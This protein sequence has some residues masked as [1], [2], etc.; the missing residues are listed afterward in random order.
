MANPPLPD[1][2]SSSLSR[3][4]RRPFDSTKGRSSILAGAGSGKTRTLVH[5]LAQDLR[6]GTPAS[7]IVAFTFTE[8]AAEELLAR[9]HAMR[10]QYMPSV[11]LSGIFIGTIHAWCLQHLLSQPAFFNITPVDELHLDA[12]AGRLYSFLKLEDVYKKPFPKGIR[13]FLADLDIFY[14]EHL[15]LDD[16]PEHIAPPIT[17]FLT[18]LSQNRLL[19]FGGMIRSAVEHLEATGSLSDLHCLYVDEYQ[20]V[21]PAQTALLQAMLPPNGKLCVVGD[22]LQSIYN[23][24]GSDV[25]RILEFRH[26]FA[27][28]EVFRLSTNY[29]SRPEILEFANTVADDIVMRDREKVMRTGRERSARKVIHWVSTEDESHQA[30]TIARIV[31]QFHDAGVPYSKIAILMRSVATAGQP[32]YEALTSVEV[33]V[34]CPILGRSAAFIDDFLLPVFRWLRTDQT[35]PRSRKEEQQQEGFARSVW[36]SVSPWLPNPGAEYE[37]WSALNRWHDLLRT[38]SSRSFNIRQCLYEFLDQCGVRIGPDDTE[39]MMGVGLCSQIIR[40]V[41]E[42]HRRR[43]RNHKRRSAVGVLSE[44]YYAVVRNHTRFGESLPLRQ[45]AEEVLLTTV[46]QAK[47]LEWPIVCLP[48]LDSRRFPLPV[49][50]INSEYPAELTE[51]YGTRIDDE[52]RLFYVAVTRAKERL[53]LL[54]TAGGGASRRSVFLEDVKRR[55]VLPDEGLV[56][57]TNGAWSV[58]Q[59][60]L[61]SD[62]RAPIAV[63]LSDLLIYL[64]CPYQFG[65]RKIAGV[66]PAVG[67]ELGFGKGLHELLQRRADCEHPWSTEEIAAEVQRHVYL[68]LAAEE[69]ER[70]A[71]GAIRRRL[72]ALQELG[73]FPRARSQELP[74]EIHLDDG[75]VTGMIDFVYTLTDGSVAVRDWKA[76][77]HEAFISR[78]T[79]Q[80]QI[81]AHALR[82]MGARVSRGELIDVAASTEA[83]ELIATEIDITEPRIT[84]LIDQ[85]GQALH[86]IR[87]GSFQATPDPLVCQS[88]DVQHLCAVRIRETN[89]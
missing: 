20:D 6:L 62:E 9:I 68:P 11:D 89:D 45:D 4:Q 33:P 8:K 2:I 55:G 29:R 25:G 1:W 21:N 48:M 10:H 34:Q 69:T 87:T 49:R 85:C 61:R 22:D 76:T 79:R 86:A 73:A 67:D 54:D 82:R 28:A 71:R 31:R 36:T 66:Q 38:N 74:V 35:P 37:F 50:G 26:E 52:R 13:P 65:L 75:I 70:T 24:R 84:R 19:P 3:E 80:V 27:P 83:G 5:L 42:V 12:L 63:G 53:F 23:W 43:L 16:I 77:V 47:G 59:E 57:P 18:I 58:P 56:G 41:E 17:A 60:D 81:Y 39:L 15:P 30:A 64:E 14:N 40:R 51:R 32:I 46:H 7:S 44:A 78:Y 72:A 88:C